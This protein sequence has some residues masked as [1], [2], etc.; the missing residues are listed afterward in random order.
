[1]KIL[2]IDEDI[3]YLDLI[4]KHLHDCCDEIVTESNPLSIIFDPINIGDYNVIIIDIKIKGLNGAMLI[5]KIRELKPDI[6]I[7]VHTSDENNNVRI[8][9]K[10]SGADTFFVKP[11]H[12]SILQYLNKLKEELKE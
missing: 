2:I 11:G 10:N 7:I 9:A 12:L 6:H 8:D 5:Q 1:M 4:K 3:V